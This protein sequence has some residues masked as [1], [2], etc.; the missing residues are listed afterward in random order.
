MHTSGL[1]VALASLAL[2]SVV[3]AG[4]VSR[5]LPRAV[6]ACATI[7]QQISG[8]SQVYYL[9]MTW[10]TLVRGPVDHGL[11]FQRLQI[12]SVTTSIT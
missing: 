8:S 4:D 3:C 11:N 5:I 1:W 6:A 10:R 12:M 7:Q 2:W 9:G